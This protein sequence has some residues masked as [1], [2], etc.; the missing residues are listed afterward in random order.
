MIPMRTQSV[1]KSRWMAVLWAIGILWMVH[2]FMSTD[3]AA[4]ASDDANTASN[5]TDDQQ[6]AQLTNSV[7]TLK[8]Q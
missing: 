8:T 2:D 7:S 3:V 1:F 6:M 5:M 4:N